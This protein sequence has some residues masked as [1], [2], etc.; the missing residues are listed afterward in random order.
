MGSIRYTIDPNVVIIKLTDLVQGD[1]AK[2]VYRPA[3][4]F[5]NIEE[6]VLQSIQGQGSADGNV[7]GTEADSDD[8][9]DRDLDDDDSV[10][11]APVIPE[12]SAFAIDADI[13]IDAQ[14]LKDM[15]STGPIERDPAPIQATSETISN[16]TPELDWEW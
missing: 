16:A 14:P 5:R 10:A 15:V 3:V 9:S 2:P 13:D 4:K 7:S 8:D 1:S 6:S 12:A 11:S